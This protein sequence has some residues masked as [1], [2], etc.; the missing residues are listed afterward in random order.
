MAP[1]PLQ[2]RMYAL[3]VACTAR[4]ALMPSL[5]MNAR[6]NSTRKL[7]TLCVTAVAQLVQSVN[8]QKLSLDTVYLAAVTA[9]NALTGTPALNV[10]MAISKKQ[11]RLTVAMCRAA[12]VRIETP[13]DTANPA[14][15]T[16]LS[17]VK[18]KSALP[19]K[20]TT[21]DRTTQ[22]LSV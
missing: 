11:S 17:A 10:R 8:M 6:V 15:N 9:H 13:L 1:I 4:P 18:S 20:L 19:A 12:M 16:V 7:P 21:S 22:P 5:A 2:T 3:H 14:E